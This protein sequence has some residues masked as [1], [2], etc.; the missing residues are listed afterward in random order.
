MLRICFPERFVKY[1]V[2]GNTTYTRRIMDGVKTYGYETGLIPS[3]FH[4]LATMTTET[5]FGL[6]RRHNTVLHYSADTGPLA[7]TR[8]PSVV[9]VHGVASRWVA[10]VRSPRHEQAWRTRVRLAIRNCDRLITVSYSSAR[11]IANVFDVNAEEMN[12]IPHGVE[13][14]R[15]ER[16]T[17]LSKGCEQL[18][19]GPFILYL[20]NIEP[21]KNVA[22]LVRAYRVARLHDN[23]IRLIVAGRPAWHY[24]D[25]MREIS[26]TAGVTHLGFVSDSDRIA[27]MQRCTLFVF[28][29]LYEGFGFPVLEALA[30]GAVVLATRRGSLADIAGP[31]L[32]IDLPTAEGIAEAMVNALSDEVARDSVRS[33][34]PSW[35][36]SFRWETSI[37]RHITVYE[38]MSSR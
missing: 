38:E 24:E 9:T 35:A 3:S 8:T 6:R 11:D 30:A 32:P 14:E 21:R 23:G 16:P 28:P 15:F 22:E 31:S 18:A 37:S 33:A 12:V 29:S 27:L 36:R 1:H 7:R 5:V 34:G 26:N 25:T 19:A 4:P 10:T 17:P 2:G 13:V 20:G